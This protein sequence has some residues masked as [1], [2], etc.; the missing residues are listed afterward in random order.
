MNCPTLWSAVQKEKENLS[1]EK[2]IYE[3]ALNMHKHRLISDEELR[4]AKASYKVAESVMAYAQAEF[5]LCSTYSPI[6]GEIIERYKQVGDWAAVGDA[7]V[8]V[9][10]T[11]HIK[12]VALIPDRKWSIYKPGSRVVLWSDIH[13]QRYTGVVELR[14]NYI[15]AETGN[16]RI[17]IKIDEPAG[18]VHGMLLFI[19]EK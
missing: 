12:M 5:N 17:E 11:T 2:A 14:A 15:D 13:Q 8:M 18:I 7:V 6:S 10:D 4:S 3:T 16:F 1:H 19:E 9:A